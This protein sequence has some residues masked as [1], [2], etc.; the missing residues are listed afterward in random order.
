[1]QALARKYQALNDPYFTVVY[2]PTLQEAILPCNTNY[3]SDLDCFHPNRAAHNMLAITLWNN[4]L[5]PP[6]HK[7]PL[8]LPF[9]QPIC[10]TD[11]SFFQ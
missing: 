4:M 7:I 8:P 11:S 1:M 9:I 5:T 2:Q 10:P 6:G 3:V